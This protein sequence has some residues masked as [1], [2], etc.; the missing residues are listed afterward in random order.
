MEERDFEMAEQLAHAQREQMIAASRT[1][2]QPEK[3]EDFD[4]LN[5][6]V[7]SNEIPQPR[8]DMGR[9]RCTNCQSA[10]EHRSKIYRT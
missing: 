6:V 9:I 2:L 3:H 10:M 4:G 8:L 5:C 1:A 7:C